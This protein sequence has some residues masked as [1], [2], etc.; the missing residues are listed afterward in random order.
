MGVFIYTFILK[1]VQTTSKQSTEHL[2]YYFYLNVKIILI[3]VEGVCWLMIPKI[4]SLRT[5][6]GLKIFF[7][8]NHFQDAINKYLSHAFHILKTFL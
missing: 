6:K 8:T 7:Y 4:E 1:W 5:V 2:I 3:V